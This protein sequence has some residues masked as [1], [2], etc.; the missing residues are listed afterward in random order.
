MFIRKTLAFLS[1]TALL[2]AAPA[3]AETT[4]TKPPVDPQIAEQMKDLRAK[5][6]ADTEK[7]LAV[8]EKM[9]PEMERLKANREKLRALREKVKADQDAWKAK[10]APSTPAPAQ[11]KAGK[12]Q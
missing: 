9:K 12:A 4:T 5:I 1:L 3:W 8:R 7:L 6:K 10:N 2:L 11:E